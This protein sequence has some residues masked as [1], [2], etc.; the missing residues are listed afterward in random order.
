MSGASLGALPPAGWACSEEGEIENGEPQCKDDKDEDEDAA[1]E[2]D[3]EDYASF[4]RSQSLE[5]GDV[6]RMKVV[7][8]RGVIVGIAAEE[9]DV[10]RHGETYTSIAEVR[11]LDGTTYIDSDI[12]EDGEEHW[13]DDHLEDHIPKTLPYDVAVRIT[14]DGNLPQIQF[15]DDSVWHDFAPE[16]GAALKAGPWFPYLYLEGDGLLSDHRVD[17]PRAT[18]SAGMKCKPASDPAPAP[19]W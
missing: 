13:H 6:W 7:A 4:K 10:E 12:S 18:K 2:E 9:Y 5:E 3:E 19:R 16:G 8:E 14:K 11:L 17:R 15:N 1:D